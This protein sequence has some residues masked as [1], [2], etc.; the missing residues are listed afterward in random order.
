LGRVIPSLESPLNRSDPTRSRAAV[1]AILLPLLAAACGGDGGEGGG[2]P[3][4]LTFAPELGVALDRMTRTPTGLLTLD[5][6]EGSGE[7]VR[8]GDG[9]V[10]HYDGWLPDGRKFDSSVDRNEAFVIPSV[11]AGMVIAGWEEG[12]QGM[13]PG[14]RRLLVI[15]PDLA[16]GPSGAGGV[17]PPNATLV[18]RVQLLQTVTGR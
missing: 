4:Q 13:R 1:I 16:Y 14:G 18:F 9:V 6:M 8:V 3:S 11:G 10:V 17:I 7:P 2:D 12:L 5:E 15:P